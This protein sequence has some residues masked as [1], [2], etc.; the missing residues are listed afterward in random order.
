MTGL[1]ISLIDMLGSYY[2]PVLNHLYILLFSQ[3]KLFFPQAA[4]AEDAAD[5]IRFMQDMIQVS[6]NRGFEQSTILDIFQ[7]NFPILAF[8]SFC[9]STQG[10][11]GM[12]LVAD[13]Y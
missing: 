1:M 6:K 11:F 3:Y 12:L 9:S 5:G 4:T 2:L 13:F 7:F 8:C 10:Y